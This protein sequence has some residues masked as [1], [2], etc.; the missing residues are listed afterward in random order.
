MASL[1]LTPVVIHYTVTPESVLARVRT[2]AGDRA[3]EEKTVEIPHDGLKSVAPEDVCPALGIDGAIWGGDDAG[4]ALRKDILPPV[5]EKPV[6]VEKTKDER[7]AILVV[8][9]AELEKMKALLEAIP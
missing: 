9:I 1:E 5:V 8:Q 2:Y 6:V 4:M 3:I 7:L